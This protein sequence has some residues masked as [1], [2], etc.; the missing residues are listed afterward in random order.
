[1][2]TKPLNTA[3]IVAG[4]LAVGTAGAFSLK[5]E[6]LDKAKAEIAGTRLRGPSARRRA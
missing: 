2:K 5:P 4:V 6:W 3:L 1:M